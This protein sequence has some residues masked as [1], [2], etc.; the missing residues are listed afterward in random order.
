VSVGVLSLAAL[1]VHTGFRLGANLN[2]ALMTTFLLVNLVGSIAGGITALEGKLDRR[3]GRVL[4]STLVFAHS[5]AIWPLPVLIVFHVL[6][7]YYF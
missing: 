3:T 6:A 2:L 7:V 4:R 1:A 5:L